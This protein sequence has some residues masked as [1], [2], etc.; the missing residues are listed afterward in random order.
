MPPAR[1][2][3][4]LDCPHRR[5]DRPLITRW[6][7]DEIGDTLWQCARSKVG[8][9]TDGDGAIC[10]NECARVRPYNERERP[11]GTT[12]PERL[13]RPMGGLSL[14]GT[15]ATLRYHPWPPP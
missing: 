2:S 13:G 11:R 10:M 5:R 6:G 7:G 12:I 1:P 8:Y 9:P 15:L 14:L 3:Y 4:W